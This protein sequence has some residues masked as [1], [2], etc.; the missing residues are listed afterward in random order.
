MTG[1]VRKAT[2]FSACGLLLAGAAMAAVP[3]PGNSSVPCGI[4]VVGQN[5]AGLTSPNHTITI[6]VK[7]L[8]NNPVANSSVVIDL[9]GCNGAADPGPASVQNGTNGELVDCVT[10]TIRAITDVTGTV[11]IDAQAMA[12]VAAV[13][14]TPNG[15]CGQIFADGVL[16][17][18]VQVAAFDLNGG[19]GALGLTAADLSAW[20]N[21]FFA[22][23]VPPTY[24]AIADYNF[25]D[26]LC[27]TQELT[28]ADLS[29]WLTEFFSNG[30]L[31]NDPI[32]P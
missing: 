24:C 1:L 27:A 28:A 20:L 26:G 3:S 12:S 21:Y 22:C 18:T 9:S 29:I 2:L 13:G 17:Q 8:A 7:D 4:K 32:C 19:L 11:S 5:G 23:A 15:A 25:V 16:L 6:Q 30:S 10:K 31:G 14:A